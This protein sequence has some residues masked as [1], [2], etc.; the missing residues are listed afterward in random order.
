MAKLKTISLEGNIGS[1]KTRLLDYIHSLGGEAE[2]L[3]EPIEVWKEGNKSLLE[4][5]YQNPAEGAMPLQKAV[6]HSLI[7][8]QEQAPTKPLRIMERS[9]SSCRYVFGQ[10]LYQEGYL[11]ESDM[12]VLENWHEKLVREQD[13]EPNLIIYVR[14]SPDVAMERIRKRARESER[15][16]SMDYVEKIDMLH[17]NWLCKGDFPVPCKVIPIDGNKE[18]EEIKSEYLRC[19]REISR[20]VLCR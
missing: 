1:G 20:L 5:F 2:I 14:S 18:G 3:P 9:L 7:A 6:I 4:E 12:G 13:Y 8:R 15:E 11:S 16:I 10:A 19:L 17:E